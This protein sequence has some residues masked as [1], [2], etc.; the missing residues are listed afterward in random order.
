VGDCLADAPG[1]GPSILLDEADD[2]HS[3]QRKLASQLGN[4][5]RR[6]EEMKGLERG[7]QGNQGGLE[8]R[9]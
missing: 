1:I 9:N 4:V 3:G 8:S 7:T 2:L 5:R 6:R